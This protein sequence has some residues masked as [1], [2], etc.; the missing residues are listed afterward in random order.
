M[1]VRIALHRVCVCARHFFGETDRRREFKDVEP[2]ELITDF[3]LG[4]SL[5]CGGAFGASLR[6]FKKI[7]FNCKFIDFGVRLKLK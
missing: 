3:D 2:I 1:R 5:R 4:C 7:T 6:L